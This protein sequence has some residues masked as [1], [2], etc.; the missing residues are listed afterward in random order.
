MIKDLSCSSRMRK[1]VN[2]IKMGEQKISSNDNPLVQQYS[3]H[4]GEVAKRFI[5]TYIK[6]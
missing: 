6:N 2:T 3:C 4:V 1:I 5:Q